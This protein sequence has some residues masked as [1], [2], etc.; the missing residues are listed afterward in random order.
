MNNLNPIIISY[1]TK[2]TPYETVIKETL[3]PSLHKFNLEHHIGEYEDRGSWVANT[4]IKGEFILECLTKFKRPICFLDSDAYINKY[5]DL[6]FKLSENIDLAYLLFN[7]YGHWR[8]QPENTS[9]ME[10]LSGTMVFNYNDKIISLC[11]EWIEATQKNL[12][13]W[14][15][16]VLENI[17]NSKKDLNIYNLPYEYC[18]VLMH[19]YTIPKYL[20]EEDCVIIHTQASRRYKNKNLW[21]KNNWKLDNQQPNVL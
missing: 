9:K 21:E 7:W 16:K 3:L 12:N 6:F 20:K 17:V 18:C 14:E 10:L 8:N 2:N 4:A 19:D 13:I 1:F 11:K 15:Q 5:P